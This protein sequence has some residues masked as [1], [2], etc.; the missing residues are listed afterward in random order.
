MQLLIHTEV[1][2]PAPMSDA[3]RTK[4]A[5]TNILM[6]CVRGRQ[7]MMVPQDGFYKHIRRF[8]KNIC[9]NIEERGVVNMEDIHLLIRKDN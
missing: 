1:N 8:I 4:A 9:D 2:S 5:V 7:W 6:L 3:I